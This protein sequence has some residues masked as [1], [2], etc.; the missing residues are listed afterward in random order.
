MRLLVADDDPIVQESIRARLERW[1]Y[2][3][4]VAGNGLEAWACL[5]ASGEFE[6]ALLDCDMPGLTG[7]ALSQRIRESALPTLRRLFVVLMSA[8]PSGNRLL[9]CRDAGADEFLQKPLD[10]RVLAS[11][12]REVERRGWRRDEFQEG[13]FLNAP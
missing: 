7:M 6:V 1:G 4:E 12:L 9:D 8:D 13:F 3:V 10:P 2:E 5:T 11:R